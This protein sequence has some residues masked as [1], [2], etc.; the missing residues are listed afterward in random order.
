MTIKQKQ[1]LLYYLGYYVGEIDGKWS[2]L[3]EI[4]TKAF[5]ADFGMS[6]NG[7]VDSKTE[8]ALKHAVTYG[9]PSREVK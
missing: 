8:K 7:I 5:Q 6:A 1:C 4:A 3:S 2:S 9:T